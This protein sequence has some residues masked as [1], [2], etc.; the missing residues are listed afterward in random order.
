[1]NR[2]LYETKTLD[3]KLV[4]CF[5]YLWYDECIF[6]WKFIRWIAAVRK[7]MKRRI[8]YLKDDEALA[9]PDRSFFL[10]YFVSSSVHLLYTQTWWLL[11][12]GGDYKCF[13]WLNK[14][15]RIT[16]NRLASRQMERKSKENEGHM[17]Y[18]Y[19]SFKVVFCCCS[20]NESGK[21]QFCC[22]VRATIRNKAKKLS[23]KLNEVLCCFVDQI[24]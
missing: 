24:D 22:L 5:F 19:D 7:W 17:I 4:E 14:K 9:L 3:G 8:N 18:K 11:L 13:Y 6:V 21:V 10:F 2:K 20:F 23:L 16:R 1:M 12:D 15:W